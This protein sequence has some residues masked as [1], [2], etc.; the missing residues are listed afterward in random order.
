MRTNTTWRRSSEIAPSSDSTSCHPAASLDSLSVE[1][2]ALLRA[3]SCSA[4]RR[5]VIT[6][7]PPNP[8]SI[9]FISSGIESSCLVVVGGRLHQ[10]G[11]DPAGRPGMQERHPAAPDADPRGLVDQSDAGAGE[12]TQRGVDVTDPVG[13][14]VKSLPRFSMNL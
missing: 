5:V 1:A 7:P 13:D 6:C 2:R 3:S 12:A 8:I 9:R 4:R 14:V 10:L 11:Q